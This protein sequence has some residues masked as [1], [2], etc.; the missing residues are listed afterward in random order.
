MPAEVVHA[1]F[2]N[3]ADGEVARCLPRV[4]DLVTPQA[5][6]LAREQASV[7]VL[8]RILGNLA[9]APAVSRAAELLLRAGTS[10]STEGSGAVRRRTHP[11]APQQS[12]GSPVHGDNLLR[13]HR[14]DGHNAAL[15]AAGVAGTESH[16]L[17]CLAAGQPAAQDGRLADLTP[18]AERLAAQD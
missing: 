13:E 8:R 15:L 12:P 3:F 17:R 5:A 4:W 9:A 16:V 1:L 6:C 2:S 10:A 18:L 7:A 14:G 11:A